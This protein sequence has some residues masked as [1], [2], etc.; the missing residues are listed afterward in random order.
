MAT[1]V[2]YEEEDRGG[3]KRRFKVIRCDCGCE[4]TL[5]N[6]WSTDC[7]CGLEYNGSGQRLAPRQF[8][9]EETGETFV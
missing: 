3:Q 2:R 7:D 9:G 6:W 8:W 4:I 5:Y 1:H